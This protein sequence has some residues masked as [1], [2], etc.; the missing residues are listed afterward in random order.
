MTSDA[1]Y[2]PSGATLGPDVKL[3]AAAVQA[4]VST[5]IELNPM[6]GEPQGTVQYVA[7]TDASP[8]AGDVTTQYAL[9]VQTATG[10][11]Q[12]VT[13]A[14]DVTKDDMV[15]VDYTASDR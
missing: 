1:A 8:R 2:L 5:A 15:G 4:A 3:G 6:T 14:G 13:A 9:A 11:L 12:L 7:T 10:A